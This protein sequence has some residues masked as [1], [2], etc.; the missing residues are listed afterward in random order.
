MYSTSVELAGYQSS[1]GLKIIRSRIRVSLSSVRQS[2]SGSRELA[3]G[4]L[5]GM[6]FLLDAPLILF[7]P[8]VEPLMREFTIGPGITGLIITTVWVGSALTKIPT[9]Y[10]L[11]H[12]PRQHVIIGSGVVLT[13]AAGVAALAASVTL[14]ATGAFLMGVASGAYVTAAEPLMSELFPERIGRALGIHGIASILG[15]II[16]PLFV[17]LMLITANWQ[18]VFVVLALAI[19]CTTGIFYWIARRADLPDVGRGD[20]QVHTALRRHWPLLITGIAI[21]CTAGFV[22]NGIFNFYPSYFIHAKGFAEHPAR[23]MLTLAFVMALPGVWFGGRLADQLPR[24][25]LMLSILRALVVSLFVLT[26]VRGTFLL[27]VMTALLGF[28]FHTLFPVLDSHLLGLLPNEDRASVYAVYSG[29]AMFG[30]ASGST[31]VGLLL[32][33]GITYDLAFQ[34]LTTGLG[35]VLCLLTMLHFLEKLPTSATAA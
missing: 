18:A 6:V 7:A 13:V 19:A 30:E 10:V 35:I 12:I 14:L 24:I 5:C 28:I 32:E 23:V 34:L 16:A 11:F 29:I 17:S 33:Q 21:L 27:I 31:A 15:T 26:A 2:A 1:T 4:S 20:Q 22:W 8:L 25:P 9:G 3:L